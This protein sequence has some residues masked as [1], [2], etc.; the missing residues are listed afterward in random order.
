MSR[1]CRFGV[2]GR[3]PEAEYWN[4]G[5]WARSGAL[6]RK[7]WDYTRAREPNFQRPNMCCTDCS[8]PSGR[9]ATS[10]WNPNI[11]WLKVVCELGALKTA[12]VAD[13]WALSDKRGAS[14]RPA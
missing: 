5:V 8:I 11:S 3:G 2:S 14:C 13:C 1:E 4:S 6:L 12:P 10:A 7:A 9:Q